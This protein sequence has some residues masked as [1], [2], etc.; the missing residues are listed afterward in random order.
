M[1]LE[2][3]TLRFEVGK[4]QERGAEG[5]LLSTLKDLTH[6]RQGFGDETRDDL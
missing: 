1:I 5:G 2:L 6:G 4:G 3:D